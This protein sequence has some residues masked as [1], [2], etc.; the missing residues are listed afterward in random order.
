[1]I[2]TPI[3]KN[4][5]DNLEYIKNRFSVPA[6]FDFVIREFEIKLNSKTV[7]AFLLFYD[8]LV[9]KNFINR[10]IMRGLVQGCSSEEKG[11]LSDIIYKR[12]IPLGPLSID[13][14]MNSAVEKLTL[15]TV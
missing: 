1:M 14:D 2:E 15:E 13:Y 5:S 3:S 6:N 8:G 7:S 9:N 11:K 12:L 4:L 10:D